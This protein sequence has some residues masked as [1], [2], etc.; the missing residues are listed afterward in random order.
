MGKCRIYIINRS[1]GSAVDA[2]LTNEKSQSEITGPFTWTDGGLDTYRIRLW[3]N[4][5]LLMTVQGLK[6]MRLV[7][8]YSPTPI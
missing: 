1:R 2:T 6:G 5:V 3:E 8:N 7:C 4:I